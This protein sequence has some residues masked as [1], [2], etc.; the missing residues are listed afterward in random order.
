MGIQIYFDFY[1]KWSNKKISFQYSTFDS[2]L[3][4]CTPNKSATFEFEKETF[5]KLPWKTSPDF[6]E[7]W[8]KVYH[9]IIPLNFAE[10]TSSQIWKDASDKNWR[11]FFEDGL[12]GNEESFKWDGKGLTEINFKKIK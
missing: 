6:L 8:D 2:K 4:H 11:I 10:N 5:N 3:T 7:A 9:K 12:T 1:S